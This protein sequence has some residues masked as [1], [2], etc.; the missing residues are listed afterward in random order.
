[1]KFWCL[2]STVFCYAAKNKHAHRLY[3]QIAEEW[4]R[5]FTVNESLSLSA[6][7]VAALDSA[8]REV[9][10]DLGVESLF[11]AWKKRADCLGDACEL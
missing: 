11:R 7:V 2:L 9:T 8:T 4:R 3:L 1:M 6:H 10:L 5:R